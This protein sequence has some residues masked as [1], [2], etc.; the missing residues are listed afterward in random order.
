MSVSAAHKNGVTFSGIQFYRLALG[1][2][3]VF[4]APS[5]VLCTGPF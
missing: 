1:S 2:F 5:S 4:V 3:F